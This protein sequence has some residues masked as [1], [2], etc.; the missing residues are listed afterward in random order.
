[1][2]SFARDIR[3]L[4]TAEDVE[5]MRD[6]DRELD[7]SSYESTRAHAELIYERLADETMPPDEP[8]PAADVE[9]FRQWIDEGCPE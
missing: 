2:V 5:H 6:F 9:R 1:M 7:L 3:P 4:F 8:W